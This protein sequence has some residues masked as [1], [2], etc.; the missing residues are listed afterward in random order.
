MAV[1]ASKAMLVIANALIPIA[2]LLFSFGYFPYKPVI[3]GIAS[4]LDSGKAPAI[5]DKVVIMVVDALRSDFVYS[6]NSG[7]YF[8]QNLIR[9]GNAL[10]FTAHAS[11]PTVTMPRIKAITTGSVP[12][13]SDVILN[14]AQSESMS[15][16]TH[17]DTILA[18]FKKGLPG[19]LV[20]YG[21]DTW[22][23]LFPDTF[24]RFDGTTSFFVSDFIEVDNNVTRHIPDELVRDDWSVIILHY[25]GL[26]H[27]GHKA[28]PR[29]SHML[30][31]QKEMDAVVEEIFTAMVEEEHLHNTLLVLCG[32][33]GM[34]EAGNHGGSSAGETSP[35]LTFISPK[36]RQRAASVQFPTEISDEFQY[37]NTVE[38]SDITPTLA[39]LLGVP[40]PLNNLGVF[41]PHFLDIWEADSDKLSITL[42]NAKQILG[43]IKMAYPKY[44]FNPETSNTN[45]LQAQSTIEELEC[46]WLSIIELL[47][48]NSVSPD[49]IQEALYRFLY[50]AQSI[51]S[52]AASSYKVSM[53]LCG[54]IAVSAACILSFFVSLGPLRRS[55]FPGIFLIGT[56]VLSGGIMFASSYVE[57]EQQFWY[58]IVTAWTTY[59]HIRSLQRDSSSILYSRALSTA[60]LA[61]LNRLVRRWNQTGQKFAGEP[62]I[63]QNFLSLQPVLLWAL[64]LLTYVQSF[65][66][67]VQSSPIIGKKWMSIWIPLCAALTMAAFSFKLSFTAADAPEIL[68]H[69]MLEIVRSNI[70][71]SLVLQ[72]RI[73]FLGISL[74]L[75]ILVYSNS[76]VSFRKSGMNA[77][78]FPLQLFHEAL[79]LYLMTQSR[80]TNIPLFLMFRAQASII[81]SVHIASIE[82]TVNFILMQHTAFFAF[83]GSNAISSVD[84][85][86]AYNGVSDYN[87]LIVGLLTFISN[88]AGPIWWI[89]ATLVQDHSP[90]AKATD[91]IALLSFNTTFNLLSVMAACTMLRTHL[92]VWTVFSPKFLYSVAWALANHIG[93]NL[94][95]ANGLSRWLV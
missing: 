46:E 14:I 56:A 10:P 81:N 79:T 4:N 45:C 11:S 13:F 73:V 87:V 85:S 70:L 36:L 12:S 86:N 19:Q 52:S 50:K 34:N 15:T 39:G 27:I 62:D 90:S 31:K 94:L 55:G 24:D 35:A 57:E 42:E 58:W 63:V 6:N 41:I 60:F 33:H 21:D 88:W 69:W 51:M 29:S 74:L 66:G 80:A 91:R 64:I 77:W 22:L 83:G 30:P 75:A 3:P 26:D 17:Q 16:L 20:M 2:V 89:S 40:I 53:L 43:I 32:D 59:I 78:Q 93:L 95:V 76:A 67:L 7:F 44:S 54:S 49:I 68:H 71:V 47:K 23:N 61:I 82:A 37:F 72:A 1:S 9:T 65:R 38:Q 92:F 5:F 28:G 25:L 8:T 18:Q 84:L 48:N